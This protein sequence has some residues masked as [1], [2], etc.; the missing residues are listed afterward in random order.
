M[1]A[2]LPIEPQ[3]DALPLERSKHGMMEG[4][5][6][7]VV[8]R[9]EGGVARRRRQRQRGGEGRIRVL[10]GLKPRLEVEVQRVV[11]PAGVGLAE[12]GRRVG[13]VLAIEGEARPARP[14][15]AK[16]HALLVLAA[17][18]PPKTRVMPIH[19][20]HHRVQRHAMILKLV[21]ERARLKIG[22]RPPPRVPHPKRVPRRQRLRAAHQ[23]VVAQRGAIVEPVPNK[24]QSRRALTA[25]R[26]AAVAR[27]RRHAA[28][29][30]ACMNDGLDSHSP[31]PAHPAHRASSPPVLSSSTPSASGAA[32][33]SQPGI[34]SSAPASPRRRTPSRPRRESSGSPS[35]R[36]R[37]SP[38][39]SASSRRRPLRRRQRA[40]SRA[41][42]RRARRPGCGRCPAAGRG[43][44]CPAT[45]VHRSASSRSRTRS[46]DSSNGPPATSGKA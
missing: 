42:R 16:V 13:E 40:A 38:S 4:R 15:V 34:A 27:M 20:A 31:E 14:V 21:D 3:V 12:E 19:V 8:E 44:A 33:R 30:D 7:R 1:L 37:S 32:H 36:A 43:S 5:R 10:L 25:A 11:D 46:D 39:R 26:A 18:R 23:R 29:H 6:V 28:A 22:K 41:R 35:R 9:V 2:L 45:L 17:V 24:Y